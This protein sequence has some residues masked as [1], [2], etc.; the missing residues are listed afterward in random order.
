MDI[1][2][3]RK[4]LDT[5]NLGAA[6]TEMVHVQKDLVDLAQAYR[7]VAHSAALPAELTAELDTMALRLD[8]AADQMGAAL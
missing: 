2:A 1:A 6:R 3:S 8:D 5:G 4:I 7:D